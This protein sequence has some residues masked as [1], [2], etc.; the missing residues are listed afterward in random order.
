MSSVQYI[1]YPFR[2]ACS[3]LFGMHDIFF[4]HA[5]LYTAQLYSHKCFFGFVAVFEVISYT[6]GPFLWCIHWAAHTICK[7]LLTLL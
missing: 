1:F 3:D 5:V 6:I 4:A 2:F 7:M